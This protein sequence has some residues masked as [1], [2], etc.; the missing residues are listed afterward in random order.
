MPKISNSSWFDGRVM[1]EPA[2]RAKVWQILANASHLWTSF[3]IS[4]ASVD[5]GK[6]WSLR[7]TG[8]QC[9]TYVLWS[10]NSYI[11]MDK[12]KRLQSFFFNKHLIYKENFVIWATI[13]SILPFFSLRFKHKV[14]YHA[15]KN[16]KKVFTF[17]KTVFKCHI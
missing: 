17:L 2:K 4:S 15:Q 7:A 13:W 16:H 11:S 14:H 9:V 1:C 3:L 8:N 10:G 12:S 5:K 6:H